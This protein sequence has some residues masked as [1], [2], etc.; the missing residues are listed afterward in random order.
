VGRASE[1]SLDK[2]RGD[3]QACSFRHWPISVYCGG[4]R[5]L[6]FD[7]KCHQSAAKSAG[8]AMGLA[9]KQSYSRRV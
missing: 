9:G 3:E 5:K 4:Q 2:A 8:R 1:T 6:Q 7:Q